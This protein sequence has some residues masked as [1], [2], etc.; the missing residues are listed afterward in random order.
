MRVYSYMGTPCWVYSL[1]I[2][3]LKSNKYD[4]RD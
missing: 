4:K 3:N 1:S 2:E